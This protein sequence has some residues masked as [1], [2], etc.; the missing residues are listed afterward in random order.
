MVMEIS[1]IPRMTTDPPVK[2]EIQP[3]VAADRE[4]PV[5]PAA[6]PVSTS[7][8]RQ[9]PPVREPAPID[10][11]EL[12]QLVSQINDYIQN[13]QR[14]LEFSVDEDTGLTV[15]KVINKDTE[16]IIR[17]IPPKEVLEMASKIKEQ[18]EE[19]LIFEAQV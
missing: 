15:V 4:N 2:P 14:N 17:Q 19:T 13:I 5:Q 11:E 9:T 16:E 7:Q 12:S 18:A 3:G 8:D 6:A 1:S 10:E